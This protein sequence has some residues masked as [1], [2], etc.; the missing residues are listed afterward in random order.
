M[1][2]YLIIAIPKHLSYYKDGK[3]KLMKQNYRKLFKAKL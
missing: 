3:L 1:R 2:L